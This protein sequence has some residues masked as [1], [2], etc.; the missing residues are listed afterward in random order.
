M[1]FKKNNK[2]FTSILLIVILVL[3]LGG[4]GGYYLL[5]QNLQQDKESFNRTESTPVNTQKTTTGQEYFSCLQVGGNNTLNK[6]DPYK[7]GSLVFK[8][9]EGTSEETILDKLKP[10][11]YDLKTVNSAWG[12]SGIDRSTLFI[13]HTMKPDEA[14][15]I[16]KPIVSKFEIVGG[17]PTGFYYETATVY[18]TKMLS[19]EQQQSINYQLDKL[20]TQSKITEYGWNYAPKQ[21]YGFLA[22]PAGKE[23]EYIEKL[24]KL[25]I[26]DCVSKEL[27]TIPYMPGP[28]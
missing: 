11:G 8:A 21:L 13:R 20:K 6:V 14:Q 24:N 19:K 2:G 4:I 10:L 22:V 15:N 27:N 3:L 9:K 7:K 17:F 5:K 23:E 28:Q 12:Y 26:F 1:R 25:G 18:F 16:L